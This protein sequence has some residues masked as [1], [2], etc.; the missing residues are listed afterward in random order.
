MALKIGSRRV[1]GISSLVQES[2]LLGGHSVRFRGYLRESPRA[3]PFVLKEEQGSK[4]PQYPQKTR[5]EKPVHP[6]RRTHERQ[7]Q[8]GSASIPFYAATRVRRISTW[9]PMAALLSVQHSLSS[10][11]DTSRR[12]RPAFK[13]REQGNPVQP[14]DRSM[15]VNG[16]TS[17][18]SKTTKGTRRPISIT[19]SA[20]FI[21]QQQ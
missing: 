12:N 3:C 16:R 8:A 14:P 17:M 10:S 11:S 19:L 20:A 1:S 21:E 6:P 7:Q 13:K 9:K 18:C 2:S 15:T 5:K 4:G